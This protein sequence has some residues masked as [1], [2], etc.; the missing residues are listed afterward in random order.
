MNRLLWYFLPKVVWPQ[1][2]LGV[3]FLPV[4]NASCKAHPEDR[5]LKPGRSVLGEVVSGYA[6]GALSARARPLVVVGAV[7]SIYASEGPVSTISIARL[8]YNSCLE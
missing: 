3:R 6:Q 8:G 4:A 5:Y 2:I 7:A 1:A